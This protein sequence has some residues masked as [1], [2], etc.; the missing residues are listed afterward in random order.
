M[1]NMCLLFI[2]IMRLQS[3]HKLMVLESHFL[4]DVVP[5]RPHKEQDIRH[6]QSPLPHH[7]NVIAAILGDIFVGAAGN[8]AASNI[9]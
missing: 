8:K 1:Q 5:S 9:I 4:Q 2:T 6:L 3:V 7:Y